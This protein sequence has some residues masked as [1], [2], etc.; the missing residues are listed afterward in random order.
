MEQSGGSNMNVDV[1]EGHESEKLLKPYHAPELTTLGPIQSVVKAH[2]GGGLDCGL[3][4][5]SA[6]AS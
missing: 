4:G 2:T 3:C 6:T 5:T 1:T